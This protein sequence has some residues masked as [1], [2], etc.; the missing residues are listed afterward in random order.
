MDN[1]ETLVEAKRT[2]DRLLER[3]GEWGQPDRCEEDSDLFFHADKRRLLR[4]WI[5]MGGPSV[6]LDVI[7][8]EETGWVDNIEFNFH[9][10]NTHFVRRVNYDQNLRAVVES[11]VEME[12]S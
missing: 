11:H 12:M 7:Y 10:G 3:A 6:F 4:L 1:E 2:L 8:D 5:T 9:W